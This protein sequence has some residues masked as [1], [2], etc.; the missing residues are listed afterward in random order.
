MTMSPHDTPPEGQLVEGESGGEQIS[1]KEPLSDDEGNEDV[2]GTF[3]V[4]DEEMA[5]VR[6]ELKS[7]F[8]ND[9]SYLSDAYILSVASKPY[10]KD[11]TRRRPLEV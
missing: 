8:P 4:T 10:S 2:E 9:H 6:A 1:L 5:Q 11:L 7:Q 3:A